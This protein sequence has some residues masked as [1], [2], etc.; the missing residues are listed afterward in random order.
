MKIVKKVF[1][2]TYHVVKAY[3]LIVSAFMLIGLPF[4]VFPI[5][6]E[7]CNKLGNPAAYLPPIYLIVGLA[8]VFIVG[9][10]IFKGHLIKLGES[11]PI[12]F[13]IIMGPLMAVVTSGFLWMEWGLAWW[14]G[15]T[16]ILGVIGFFGLAFLTLKI[17][18]YYK[19]KAIIQ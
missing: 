9:F 11:D 7:Y 12:A 2:T 5:V 19:R 10:K 15:G 16:I 3:F 8:W 4:T 17:I 13:G 18:K 14:L 1:S 6:A